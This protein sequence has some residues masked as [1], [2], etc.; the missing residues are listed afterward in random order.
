R[1]LGNLAGDHHEVDVGP[2]R[3]GELGDQIDLGPANDLA[4]G[5]VDDGA[6]QLAGLVVQQPDAVGLALGGQRHRAA[7]EDV[8][9]EAVVAAASLG[10]A[11]LSEVEADGDAAQQQADAQPQKPTAICH[12]SPPAA[13]PAQPGPDAAGA[14]YTN[15]S[16]DCN[17]NRHGF[18]A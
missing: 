13:R 1:G 2:R 17:H 8:V 3:Q 4:L 5:A 10:R 16:D 15:P 11:G 18:L 12:G 14:H 6:E 9:L 7:A